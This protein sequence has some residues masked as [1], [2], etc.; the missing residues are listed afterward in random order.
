MPIQATWMNSKQFHEIVS[1]SAFLD[2]FGFE[3][4]GF[5]D[6]LGRS[7]SNRIADAAR[8]QDFLANYSVGQL[9]AQNYYAMYDMSASCC[10]LRFYQY[11]TKGN[12]HTHAGDCAW[13]TE[14]HQLLR[15]CIPFEPEHGFA[16]STAEYEHRN[17]F[18]YKSQSD[19][20]GGCFLGK[21]LAKYF[22]GLY[23]VNYFS[24]A[25]LDSRRLDV[26]K[27]EEIAC[28]VEELRS[29]RIIRL[30]DSCRDWE[31]KLGD[32]DELV[33]ASPHFFSLED[34]QHPG[35]DLTPRER[36]SA[37]LAATSKWP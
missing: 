34:V 22:P 4:F 16:C 11:E 25:L 2:D 10:Y 13:V 14:F 24:N 20:T 9:F 19:R 37:Y 15:C 29:G 12:S 23:Y 3:F 32:I 30:H 18:G 8:F 35:K 27:V 1:S 33:R 36:V 26:S 7:D 28:H 6:Q 17:W 31:S 5:G 21:D